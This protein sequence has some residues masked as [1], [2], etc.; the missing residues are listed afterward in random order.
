[1]TNFAFAQMSSTSY[2]IDW[3]SLNYGGSD[4]SSSGSYILRDTVGN[5]GAGISSSTNYST[6]AGYRAGIFDEF[7]SFKIF[8]QENSSSKSASILAGNTV[9]VSSTS[10]FSA[11]D[12]IA[13]V[14]DLGTN[15]VTAIGK[16]ESVGAEDFTV[17]FWSDNGTAPVVDG[18]DDYV[19]LLDGLS[20]DFGTLSASSVKTIVIGFEVILD[21]DSGYSVQ[22]M[23]D[24]DLRS[25]A[26]TI[27]DVA[28]GTVS[29]GSREYGAKSSDTTLANS[30]FDTQDTAITSIFQDIA[31][32]STFQYMSRDFLTLKAAIDSSTSSG[33]YAQILTFIASGNF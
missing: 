31:T 29:I 3:D 11:G 10:G 16:I 13:L 26:N 20:T 1:M 30:T 5:S 24:G 18:T 25:G 9:T 17:D 7:I 23:E 2:Q 15:Q 14:Q 22:I 12:Y 32:E 4:T 8:G 33:T 28:D 19:Y 6:Q 27:T 21:S